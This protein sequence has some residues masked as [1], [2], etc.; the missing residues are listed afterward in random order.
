MGKDA[1]AKKQL[2]FE[3]LSWFRRWIILH[4]AAAWYVH[5]AA[6][7]IYLVTGLTRGV[8]LGYLKWQSDLQALDNV[9]TAAPKVK[10]TP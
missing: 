7:P 4:P 2:R 8:M 5:A 3:D 1:R 10:I 6:A 9:R